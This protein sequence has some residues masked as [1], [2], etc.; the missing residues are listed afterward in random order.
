M[1]CI[2]PTHRTV[3]RTGHNGIPL[4]HG[5]SIPLSEREGDRRTAV[6]RPAGHRGGRGAIVT[7]GISFAI[8]V[9]VTPITPDNDSALTA[10]IAVNAAFVLGLHRSD[11]PRIASHRRARRRGKAASRL[12]VRIVAMFTIVAAIPA[13][14]VAIIAS[15]TLDIGLDRW[16][17]IRTKTIV[18]SSLSIAEAYVQENA[19]NLQGTTLSMA[20]DLD[21]AQTLYNL[22][23]T[24]FRDFMSQQ[25]EG[26]AL[27]HAALIRADGSF[28]IA[29]KTSSDFEM[30][31][32]PIEAVRTAADGKPVLIEPRIRNIVGA[33]V[34]LRQID[35]LY[36]YTI[37]LVDPRGHPGAPDRHGQH[38]RLSRAGGQPAP[39]ADGLR[40]ALS[41]R[42]AGHRIQPHFNKG[43]ALFTPI[44][45]CEHRGQRHHLAT[46][47][48]RWSQQCRGF[49][50]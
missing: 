4:G 36:L 1:R 19:R 39:D 5:T 14:I 21:N 45:H 37:R 3:Q 49:L 41:R 18:N 34:K 13:I 30:P 15:I 35:D 12:H 26:R 22:D 33:V 10:I 11:R 40:A 29:A 8:L 47:K 46:A 9:G 23:R 16:F 20:Y 48:F 50:L 7:A 28:V 42:H 2:S 17:E 43:D 25:A 38:Q 27:A 31:Q 6:A 32:V 24:G 44:S